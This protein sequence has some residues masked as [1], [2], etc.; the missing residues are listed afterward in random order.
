[1][2]HMQREKNPK[3]MIS[4]KH[5]LDIESLTPND[6]QIFLDQGAYYKSLMK[7]Q[8]SVPPQ[9]ENKIILT[10]FAEPS[11]RTRNSFEVAALRLG[12]RLIN[13]DEKT[14]SFS[15]GESFSDT[16]KYLNGYGMDGMILRHSEYNAPYFVS[17][18]VACP[19]INAGDSWREHPT[20]A[21]L[22][23]MTMIEHK[24]SLSQ[25]RVAI[26]GDIAHSRVANSN[27]A[28]LSKMGAHVHLIA[29]QV[30]QLQKI[31]HENVYQFDNMKDG[32][33]DCD[34]VMMLRLQKERMEHA[35]IADETDYFHQFGLTQEKLKFAKP[36]A[37]VMHPGPM[38]RGVEIADDV[39]DD[40]R[41]SVILEQGANGVPLRMA[42][43]D[44]LLS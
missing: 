1:M 42:V 12:A 17:N 33:K 26:C 24:K 35:L 22:D 3:D 36:D 18:L 4:V 2:I 9:L 21:L 7:S 31:K 38:N 6:I 11:T 37:I 14:S 44:L 13:F 10:F 15:K 41:A 34:V 16:I 8:K 39:A 28:L 43:L 40:P 19:V 20:Q 25:L 27:I 30:L 23:A 29:P 32:L 5:L